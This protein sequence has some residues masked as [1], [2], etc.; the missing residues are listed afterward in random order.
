MNY[1]GELPPPLTVQS[2]TRTTLIVCSVAGIVVLLLALGI[3]SGIKAFRSTQKDS[4]D[5]II[6][7]N[8]FIDSMSEHHYQAARALLIPQ[9]QPTTP[10]GNLQD[11]QA[12]M[13]KHHGGLVKRG[14]PAW[15][16]QERGGQTTVRLQYPV[17]YQRSSSGVTLTLLKTNTGYRVYNYYYNF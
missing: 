2:S 17:Q 10:A 6:V 16:A 8:S 7:G 5:A 1:P 12:L 3:V 14:Q 9:L 11:L 13:E 4:Q 15:F